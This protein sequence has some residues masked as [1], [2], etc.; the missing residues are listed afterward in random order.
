MK[1]IHY[2]A[3]IAILIAASLQACATAVQPKCRHRALYQAISY[4][5]LVGW[6]VR[7]A[8]GP[9]DVGMHAQAQAQRPDGTWEWLEQGEFGVGTGYKDMVPGFE[10]NQYVTVGEFLEWMGYSTTTRVAATADN[11]TWTA[12]DYS[13]SRSMYDNPV[14][15]RWSH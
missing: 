4:K 6:P 12:G 8:I 11:N 14:I 3:I 5:D 7:I 2:L 13:S 15:D 1:K 9:S 10:P